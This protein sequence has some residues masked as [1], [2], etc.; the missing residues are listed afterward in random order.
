M[1]SHNNYYYV[2]HSYSHSLG[3]FFLC[4]LS[5]S[6]PVVFSWGFCFWFFFDHAFFVSCLCLVHCS[7]PPKTQ[8]FFGSCEFLPM[9][10]IF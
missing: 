4:F 3:D 10:V 1:L 2:Y 8:H 5:P 9:V 6:P 7:R